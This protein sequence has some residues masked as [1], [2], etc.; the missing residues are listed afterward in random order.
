LDAT[1][2]HTEPVAG[3]LP[4]WG[5]TTNSFLSPG[6][7]ERLSAISRQMP[8]IIATGRSKVSVRDFEIRFADAG[9]DISEWILEHGA[10]VAGK[11]GWTRTVLEG[12]DL[13][14][15]RCEIE[16]VIQ[17]NGFPIDT[18]R[19]QDE[20]EA[21][22][23][24]AGKSPEL[25]EQFI[26]SASEILDNHFRTIPGKKIE[27]I[28]KKGDKFAAFHANFGDK[29]AIAFAAGD[30]EDDLS[31]LCHARIP[32]STGDAT[33]AVQ[34]CIVSKKGFVSKYRG[35]AGTIAMLDEVLRELG[36]G[37]LEIRVVVKK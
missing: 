7:L 25:A 24:L 32:L 8:V 20:R 12:I 14:A 31:L 27:I 37:G 29:Y 26:E 35:H 3:G 21:I 13:E 18:T 34:H 4:I 17:A 19:Y 22:L 30:H 28:P 33:P 1:L 15:V 11:P 16:K 6:T 23:I 9:I 36:N 2:C 10:V 5:R